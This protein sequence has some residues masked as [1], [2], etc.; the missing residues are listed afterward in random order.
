M[1]HQHNPYRLERWGTELIADSENDR[2]VE[3]DRE[4]GE[5]VW[6]YGGKGLLRYPRD[7]D[8]LPNGNT[9]ITDTLNN[10]VIE[11]DPE[12]EIVWEY[13]GIRI[14]YSADRLSVPEEESRTVP[15]WR[16]EGRTENVG[17]AVGVVRQ[18]EGWGAWVFPIWMRLPEMASFLGAV[19]AGLAAVVD[20]GVGWWRRR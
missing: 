14:P 10:R 15:G 2:I 12:G 1:Y 13:E 18:L 11:I 16:L 4:S 20:L 19:L 9:L 5:I 3:I 17:A 6:T 8:R 7:A